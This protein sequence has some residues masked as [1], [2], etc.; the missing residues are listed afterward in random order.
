[1]NVHKSS[2]KKQFPQGFWAPCVNIPG[3]TLISR[4]VFIVANCQMDHRNEADFWSVVVK[5]VEQASPNDFLL[6][7]LLL[8]LLHSEQT[9]SKTVVFR[10]TNLPTGQGPLLNY[11]VLLVSSSNKTLSEQPLKGSG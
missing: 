8:Q 1:M 4:R 3:F 7:S 10:D 9:H 2:I 11:T 6:F 5:P